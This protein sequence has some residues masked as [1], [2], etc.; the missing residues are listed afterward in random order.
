[1]TEK[2]N[3][4]QDEDTAIYRKNPTMF[5]GD[6]EKNFAKQIA[7][8]VGERIVNQTIIYFPLDTH[9]T[10]YHPVYGEALVKKFHAPVEVKAYVA[11]KGVESENNMFS[12]DKIP[13]IEVYFHAR[14]LREDLDGEVRE[15]DFILYGRDYYEIAKLDEPKR[16][17][18]DTSKKVEIMA[19]C[20]KARS[21]TFQITKH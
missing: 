7:D 2:W 11:W 12:L 8:E 6:K 17:Y 18:G 21:G 19:V 16:L 1:M 14:R 4:P 13:S 20:V 5:V 15:G 10:Q 9:K 3:L